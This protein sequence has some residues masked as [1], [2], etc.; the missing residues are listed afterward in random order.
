MSVDTNLS[1]VMESISEH[2]SEFREMDFRR[3]MVDLRDLHTKMT[4]T[5]PRRGPNRLTVSQPSIPPAV[6]TSLGGY[7]PFY[8]PIGTSHTLDETGTYLTSNDQ[9]LLVESLRQNP[10]AR[11]LGEWRVFIPRYPEHTDFSLTFPPEN[12]VDN[13]HSLNIWDET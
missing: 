11:A 8:S 3:I 12:Y 10:G 2:A 1:T 7:I 5:P 13:R 4:Q 6:T 9:R